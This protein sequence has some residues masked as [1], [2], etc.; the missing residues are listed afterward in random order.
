MNDK[1]IEKSLERTKDKID[2]ITEEL[3]LLHIKEGVLRARLNDTL[4]TQYKLNQE[5]LRS[6]GFLN[7]DRERANNTSASTSTEYEGIEDIDPELFINSIDTD[8]NPLKIG[9]E[10]QILT[11]GKDNSTTG[12]VTKITTNFVHC[13][14]QNNIPIKRSSINLRIISRNHGGK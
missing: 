4:S 2:Q 1:S 10:V 14:D 7:R 6:R 8:G 3:R 9:S 12:I 11:P 13:T 5:A